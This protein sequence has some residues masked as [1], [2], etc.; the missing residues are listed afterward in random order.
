MSVKYGKIIYES[1]IL[2]HCMVYVISFSPELG[3]PEDSV[4]GLTLDF[5]SATT[6]FFFSLINGMMWWSVWAENPYCSLQCR[7]EN[8]ELPTGVK[9]SMSNLEYLLHD[10]FSCNLRALSR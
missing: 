2:G 7:S 1:L 4:L 5:C 6:S 10:G 9:L 8:H 3:L